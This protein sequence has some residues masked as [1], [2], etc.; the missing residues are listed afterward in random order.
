ML[1]LYAISSRYTVS[2]SISESR[3]TP[4]DMKAALCDIDLS[5]LKSGM[6]HKSLGDLG[7]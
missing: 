3:V 7:I 6:V 4:T 2:F 5:F 1:C